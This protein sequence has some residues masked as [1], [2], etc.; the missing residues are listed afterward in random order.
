[1]DSFAHR[2]TDRSALLGTF[3]TLGSV[4]AVELAC[5]AGF[6]AI[7]VD[8]QHGAFELG[9]LREAL[10]AIQAT[11]TF[12]IARLPVHALH[13]VE[14]LLDAGYP[15]LL[16]P[17][18][19]SPAE[20]QA[21]VTAS[22]Y[23]PLGCRSQSSCR[24]SLR[25]EN[26]RRQFNDDFTLLVMIEHID[27]VAQVEEIAAIPGVSGCFLG[28]TDLASSMA[29]VDDKESALAAAVARVRAACQA[30]GKLLGIAVPTLA[31][32]VD[33]AD[34]GFHLLIVATDR[35]YLHKAMTGVTEAWLARRGEGVGVG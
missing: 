8:G 26:Y 6:D 14:A 13:Q 28:L 15:A 7:I 1:M 34:Q 4:E 3:S 12:P 16:A 24:A 23:P 10:R 32:A 30:A 31:A 18:V 20:A 2:L 27:A 21:L 29:G 5:H 35:R 33:Y 19:N 17:M 9:N 11:G 25:E 22:Y